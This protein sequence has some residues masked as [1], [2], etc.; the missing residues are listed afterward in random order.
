MDQ[1]TL[2]LG[3]RIWGTAAPLR[4]FGGIGLGRLETVTGLAQ[5]VRLGARCLLNVGAP[6]EWCA[7]TSIRLGIDKPGVRA[8]ATKEEGPPCQTGCSPVR[9]N[10]QNLASP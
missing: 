3:V 8:E 10:R 2:F 4:I 5:Q 7:I 1:L 6:R 9:E